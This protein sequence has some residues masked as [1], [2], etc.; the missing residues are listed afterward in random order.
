MKPKKQ[1]IDVVAGYIE[2]HAR[3]AT[4]ALVNGLEVI[5]PLV[6]NHKDIALNEFNLDA[7]IKKKSTTNF[8]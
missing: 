6:I 3:P 2:P 5:S 7:A 4:A 1:G 8:S